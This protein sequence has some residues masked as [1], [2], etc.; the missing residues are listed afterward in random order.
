MRLIGHG[1]GGDHVGLGIGFAGKLGERRLRHRTKRGDPDGLPRSRSS[2]AC[3]PPMD[4]KL[5]ASARSFGDNVREGIRQL[6]PR[7]MRRPT[8][9]TPNVQAGNMVYI[10]IH[11]PFAAQ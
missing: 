7:E 8:Q 5:P 4:R 3:W 11:A 9:L 6:W 1:L 2:T 10:A